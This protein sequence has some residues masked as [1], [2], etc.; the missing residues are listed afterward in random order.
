ML[1]TDNMLLLYNIKLKKVKARTMQK[2]N[3]DGIHNYKTKLLISITNNKM[4][5]NIFPGGPMD[6]NK[7]TSS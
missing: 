3:T 7:L 2:V 1:L 6:Y 4:R 5:E